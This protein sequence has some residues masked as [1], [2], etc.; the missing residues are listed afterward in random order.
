MSNM[1]RPIALFDLNDGEPV[2]LSPEQR[3]KLSAKR[4]GI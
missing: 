4:K 2:T 3:E 1:S